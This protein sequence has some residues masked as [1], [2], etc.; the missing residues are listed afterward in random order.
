MQCEAHCEV[1]ANMLILTAKRL[2]MRSLNSF[3]SPTRNSHSV[4]CIHYDAL[5]YLTLLITGSCLLGICLFD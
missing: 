4:R 5:R 1:H 3:D 2:Q